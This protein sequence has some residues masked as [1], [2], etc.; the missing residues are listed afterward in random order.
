MTLPLYVALARRYQPEKFEPSR[1]ELLKA[2]I[3]A[4][5]L[6]LTGACASTKKRGLLPPRVLV[7]GAGFAGLACASELAAAGFRVDV[8]ESRGRVGGRVHS[9]G[10]FV[11]NKNVEAG[12]ELIG[13]NHPSW[14]TLA[15]RFRLELLPIL[16]PTDLEG[17]IVLDGRRLTR[18]ESDGLWRDLDAAAQQM[19]D[20]AREIDAHEP[21]ES[22]NADLLDLTSVHTWVETRDVAPLVKRGLH[23]EFAANNGVETDAQSLLAQ[24][25]QVKGG[26]VEGYWTDSEIYRCRGG[27]QRL[28]R[29][30]A[31]TLGAERLHMS[32]PVESIRV[33][34]NG[35]RVTCSKNVVFDVD[36]VVLAVPP[37]V[38]H[39]IRFEPALPAEL[40]PQMGTSVKFIAA[41][42]RRFWRDARLSQFA[43]TDG[44]VSVTWDPTAGQDNGSD[45]A[46]TCFSSA[47]AASACRSRRG[48]AQ[49][50]AYTTELERLFPGIERQ[51]TVSRFLDWPLDPNTAAG[52]SF[53]APGEV[54]SI[55]PI[56]RAGLG[57]L[58]FAGEHTSSKFAGY[59]EGALDSGI[60]LA[61][62]LTLSCN[63][64]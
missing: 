34:A 13:S 46:L 31:S 8:V 21:W 43:L 39:R 53:P 49:R 45:A 19:N 51:M 1:R 52:Y 18:A 44:E 61:H 3:L 59:M 60:S 42:P 32:A 58:H 25:A 48:L 15:E 22:A 5:S 20:L 7:V 54:T 2:S 47:R 4:T 28:A 63:A 57:R 38:W 56:L 11:P 50:A 27:N 24:L 14:I 36:H 16:E 62:E 30:L 6:I 64:T 41:V 29:A 10:D 37:S 40:R 33:T 26:G 12:G 17:P 55:S 9:F 23:I 35:A